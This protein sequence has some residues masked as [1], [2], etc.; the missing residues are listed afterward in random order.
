MA[1]SRISPPNDHL[2]IMSTLLEHLLSAAADAPAAEALVEAA[3][4]YLAGLGLFSDPQTAT[5]VANRARGYID[6]L[7]GDMR[8]HGCTV[9]EVDAE[10]VLAATPA[11]WSPDP[12]ERLVAQAAGYLPRAVRLEFDGPYAAIY[13]RAA[14]TSILLGEDGSVTL[15]GTPFRTGRMERFGE[16]FMRRSAPLALLGDAVGLRALFLDTVHRLRTAQVPLTDLCVYVTL[17]K[18]PQ[19]YRRGGTREEAYE[20]LLDAGVRTWRVGQRIRYFRSRAGRPRLLRVIDADRASA[21]E[22]DSEYY[23]QRLSALYC[24]QFAQAFERADYARIFRVPTGTGP[25]APEPDL[26]TIRTV[27]TL[28]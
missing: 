20:V 23:V 1:A 3:P 2:D 10:H 9:V 17:H 13:A 25:F 18:S 16:E 11:D 6:R 12:Q 7:V 5:D 22:A 4:R 24:Q 15:V 19:Q 26:A 27:A 21:E 14:R 28:A 8:G